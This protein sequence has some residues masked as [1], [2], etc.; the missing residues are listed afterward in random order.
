MID[1]EYETAL[2]QAKE[3]LKDL[4]ERGEEAI[5]DEWEE[6][7]QEIFTPAE[8]AAMNLKVAIIS[9][10]IK[11]RQERGISQNQLEK[12]SGIKQSAIAK[13][14]RGRITATVDTLQKLLVPLG[15]QLVI[16]SL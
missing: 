16:E 3:N 4:E 10:L 9:E 8:I 15:K 13:M 1:T 2:N 11:A 14:E 5:S 6:L 12:M 7:K